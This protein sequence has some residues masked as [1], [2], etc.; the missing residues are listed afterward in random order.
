MSGPGR[1]RVR[2]AILAGGR[3][4]R[5]GGRKATVELAGRPLIAYP[6]AAADAAGLDPVV[7]AKRG[8]PLPEIDCEVVREPDTPVHPLRGILT[9]LEV[10][11]GPVLTLGCDMP[12]VTA[13][14]LRWLVEREPAAVA[15]ID[16]RLEPLLALYGACD[17][18]PLAAA[19][20]QEEP[21]RRAVEG[22]AP[23]RV[24]EAELDQFGDPR[25]LV[26]SVNTEADLA[27]AERLISVGG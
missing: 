14:L 24:G 6:L 12:F 18:V 2:A 11:D 16:G 10:C 4:T 19:L 9:A 15:E 5:L 7:V 21:L 22:L 20:D 13:E 3:A 26:R 17:A 8:S 23:Q 1:P 25:L 27:E